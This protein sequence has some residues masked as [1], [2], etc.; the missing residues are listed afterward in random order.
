MKDKKSKGA[1]IYKLNNKGKVIAC[2]EFKGK[3]LGEGAQKELEGL[4][5]KAAKLWFVAKDY[6][7]PN[8]IHYVY[9]IDPGIIK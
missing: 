1:Y 4:Q 5:I 8:N 9:R 2:Y 3:K 7:Q 6:S